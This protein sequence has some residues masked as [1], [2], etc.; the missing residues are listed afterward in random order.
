LAAI[1][2]PALYRRASFLL[3]RLGQPV[4]PAG[5]TIREEPQRPG[6]LNSAAFDDDGVATRDKAL[7]EDGRLASYLLDGY[8]ARKLGL[9]TTGNAGGARN[10]SSSHGDATLPDLIRRMGRGL[11][12]TELMGFGVNPVTG[13]YSRGASGL[14]V[15]GG[16]IQ[17]PVEE[18]TLS[19]NL[20]DMLLRLTEI[21][22]DVDRRGNI[23]IGS[24]L[25]EGMTL[26]GN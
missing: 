2:G 25:V 15:E 24:V 9:T 13:D 20:K 19:G 17:Y 11:L 12:V 14:W 10:V 22:A 21:G 5:L 3:D 18:I 7:V 6:E 4:C 1:Q 23:H 16:E 8:S 26:A